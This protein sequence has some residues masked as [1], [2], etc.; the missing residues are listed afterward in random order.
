MDINEL[1]TSINKLISE[2]SKILIIQADN[3][4]GDSI[5]SAL[6]LET[7]LESMGKSVS[8]YC[9]VET[10]GYLK[11]IDGWS[12]VSDS[13]P[14][15]FDVSII[16][17]TS[18]SILLGKLSDNIQYSKIKNNPVIIIDHHK[19]VKCDINY[20][21]IV[22]ND[23]KFASTGELIYMIAKKFEWPVDQ[24]FSKYVLISILSDTLGLSTESATPQTFRTVA[25]ILE[26][27][28]SR[29]SIEESR[30][31]LSKMEEKVFRYKADLIKRS[32]F[33]KNNKI[34]LL[35]LPE[36]E[37]FDVGTL[38]NPGPLISNDLLMVKNVE[39]VVIIKVYKNR[40]TGSIR[41]NPNAPIAGEL[42]EKY[43]GGGHQYA[44]GFKI[45]NFNQ[46][47]DLFINE[48]IKETVKLT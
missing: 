1:L 5:A 32:R 27:G 37:L 33:Y 2:S 28:V 14:N 21:D 41:T 44:A 7:I 34:A 10:P 19:N 42:A 9:G 29:T 48:L 36:E 20:A 23:Y 17:D 8:L 38:Y 22:L 47:L 40:I 39:V 46:N 18:S 31:E 11:Y 15:E 26:N 43:G 3:P 35:T 45:E 16:V 4:D 6:A 24:D 12:R 25:E 30:K 13:L